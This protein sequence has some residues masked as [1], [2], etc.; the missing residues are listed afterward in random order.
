[1]QEWDSIKMVGCPLCGGLMVEGGTCRACGGSG[2]GPS[3]GADDHGL[4]AGNSWAPAAYHAAAPVTAGTHRSKRGG[5][6]VPLILGGAGLLSLVA[7]VAVYA[8]FWS[9]AGGAVPSPREQVYIADLAKVQ[10]AVQQAGQEFMVVQSTPSD[11][12]SGSVEPAVQAAHAVEQAAAAWK[13]RESPSDGFAQE[14]AKLVASLQEMAAAAVD[15]REGLQGGD[16][17]RASAGAA[18]FLARQSEFT[19]AAN[20]L[21]ERMAAGGQAGP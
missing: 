14:H 7:L 21:F 2:A 4:G 11:V 9:G 8:F 15:V 13:D 16:P 1:M 20:I 10:V 18:R 17:G 5:P 12:T 6:S 19:V 3:I